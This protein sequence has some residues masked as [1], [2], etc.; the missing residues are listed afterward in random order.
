MIQLRGVFSGSKR[1]APWPNGFKP[2]R[3]MGAA[4]YH[5]ANTYL[6]ILAQWFQARTADGRGNTRKTEAIA[7]G[8]M[9][10]TQFTKI[11][12]NEQFYLLILVGI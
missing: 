8:I 12:C 11:S 4:T 10:K 9:S 1:T 5:K 3:P 6:L 7:T 2:A